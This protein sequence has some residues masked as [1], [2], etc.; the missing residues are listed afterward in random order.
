MPVYRVIEKSHN[1]KFYNGCDE[2]K[3]VD[4][5]V[6]VTVQKLRKGKHRSRD[7]PPSQQLL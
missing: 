6:G 2:G 3:L 1:P 7:L 4:E 5:Y